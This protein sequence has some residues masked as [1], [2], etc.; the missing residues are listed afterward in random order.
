MGVRFQ[1]NVSW[2]GSSSSGSSRGGGG[3]TSGGPRGGPHGGRSQPNRPS[4][5][6][7]GGPPGRGDTGP[8]QAAIESA[9][10]ANEAAR[11]RQQEKEANNQ[12]VLAAKKQADQD[13]RSAALQAAHQSNV[14]KYRTGIAELA[15]DEYGRTRNIYDDKGNAVLTFKDGQVVRG[16]EGGVYRDEYG[17]FRNKEYAPGKIGDKGA[18]LSE[19]EKMQ[20]AALKLGHLTDLGDPVSSRKDYDEGNFLNQLIS[21]RDWKGDPIYTGLGNIVKDNWSNLVT[22][23]DNP[24][25]YGSGYGQGAMLQGMIKQAGA[26]A[27]YRSGGPGGGW[28]S[29][30]GGGYG[31]GGG[32]GG[33][34]YSGGQDPMQQGYQRGQV[35]PGTLQEQV[36]QIYLGMSSL[37]QTPGFNKS[38]GGIVSLLG[39][40]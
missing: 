2:G 7:G 6:G 16:D 12:K 40:N 27:A 25:G 24:G 33:Y 22:A 36:N 14:D 28:G 13:A 29:G 20:L 23:Y 21:G 35:G 4:G 10:R 34:G 37:N 8:S 38:R 39:L 30:W 9:R 15:T 5:G 31:G 1:S 26:D 19:Y 32:G 3:G 18:L 17:Q 11:K